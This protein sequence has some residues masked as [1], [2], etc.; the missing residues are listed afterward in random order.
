MSRDDLD[1]KRGLAM[2]RDHKGSTGLTRDDLDD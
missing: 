1:D 2:T